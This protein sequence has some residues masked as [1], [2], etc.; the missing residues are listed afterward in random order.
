MAGGFDWQPAAVALIVLAAAAYVARRALARL[1]SMRAGAK[2]GA[3]ACGNCEP[4]RN[5]PAGGMA[6]KVLV[7]IEPP[8]RAARRR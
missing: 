3:P 5:A 2:P 1:R 4:E 6:P 7:Q 8:K